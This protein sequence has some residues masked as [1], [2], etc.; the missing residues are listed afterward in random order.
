MRRDPITLTAIG[1]ATLAFAWVLWPLFG[2]IFWATTMAIV[3]APLHGLLL[4]ALPG[5]RNLAAAVMILGILVLIVLPA[6]I[7]GVSIYRELAA[8]FAGIQSGEIDVPQMYHAMLAGL[9]DWARGLAA[10]LGL[11]DLS[12]AQDGLAASLRGWVSGAVAGT[13]G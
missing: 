12:A 6:L 4:R 8:L 2:A 5:R 13:G 7:L 11:G 1:L 3:F 10:D 9:P